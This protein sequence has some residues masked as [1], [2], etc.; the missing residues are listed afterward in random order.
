[1][2]K[3]DKPERATQNRLITLFCDELGYRYLGNWSDRAGNTNIEEAF[4]EI[5][6]A[7]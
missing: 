7:N 4:L 6:R 1:M 2:S 5:Y 3:I